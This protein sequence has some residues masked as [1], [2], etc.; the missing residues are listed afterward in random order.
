LIRFSPSAPG[1]DAR[2]V[3]PI[4]ADELLALPVRLHGLQLGRPVDVLLDSKDGRALGLDVHC[5]DDV[6]RFLPFPTASVKAHELAIASPLV[7]LDEDQL[8]FY[9]TR[10]SSLAALRGSPVEQDGRPAGT[11]R[12]VVIGSRGAIVEVIAASES[13]ERRLPYDEKVQLAPG[14]RSAA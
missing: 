14:S 13:G 5:G 10:T 6:H 2:V 8:A 4:R 9:R 7:L 11:L 3:K 1:H 12:D